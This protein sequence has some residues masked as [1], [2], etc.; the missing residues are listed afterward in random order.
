L[1]SL[2]TVSNFSF[3]SFDNGLHEEFSASGETLGASTATTAAN[4]NR[5]RA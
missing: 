5:L 3:W 2:E 1:R 4:G